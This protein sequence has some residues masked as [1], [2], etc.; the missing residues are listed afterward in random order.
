MKKP[1]RRCRR[2][3]GH[4]VP[5]LAGVALA[6]DDYVDL[7]QGLAEHGL[8]ST[9]NSSQVRLGPTATVDNRSAHGQLLPFGVAAEISRERPFA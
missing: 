5:V 2:G 1:R 6:N 8:E 4:N 9:T 7:L 3:S